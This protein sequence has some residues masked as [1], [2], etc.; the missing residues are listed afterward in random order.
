[1]LAPE[2]LADEMSGKVIGYLSRPDVIKA[3]KNKFQS[4]LQ[5]HQDSIATYLIPKVESS[6]I[7]AVDKLVTPDNI[8]NFW[9]SELEPRLK[10]ED[11]RSQ[12]AGYIV[13]F[14]QE[15][16][17]GLVGEIRKKMRAHLEL[18][19][20]SIPFSDK[21][22]GFVMDF[23]ADSDSMRNLIKDW[24]G[25]P[26]TLRMLQDKMGI[27]AEK[28]N[29]WINSSEA[30]VKINAFSMDT[31]AKL[32]QFLSD[33]LHEALPRFAQN[34]LESEK[35]WDWFEFQML[36]DARKK[37]VV[38]IHDHKQEIMDN[39]NLAQRI[40]KAINE[41]DVRKFHEMINCIA[42]QHPGAIQVLGF[43]LGIIVG[44]LQLIQTLL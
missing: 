2:R 41:Q 26:R 14:G 6:L 5:Q 15:N 44:G 22:I 13:K 1:L 40:E 3:I 28:L 29:E 11:T 30:E 20:G 43:V 31:K 9:T 25:D 39:L 42:A 7:E 17:N 23:F 10:N 16:A 35:L 33:Y 21:I 4:F 38:F 12:I 37:L 19:L 32:K 36:P 27:V 8:K 24:L 34:A 18:K